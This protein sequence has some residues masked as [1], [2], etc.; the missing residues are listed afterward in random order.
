MTG[1]RVSVL[2][3]LLLALL[4][5][6]ALVLV[7][8]LAR[9]WLVFPLRGGTSGAPAQF[10]IADG[11]AVRIPTGEGAV[12]GAWFLPATGG[13]ATRT[14]VVVWF[15]G[16]GETVAA[17]APV[18]RE[19]RVPGV[20]LLAVD[21]R[22]YGAS[23]GRPTVAN[24]ERD[25]EAVWRWLAGRPDVDTT[26]VVVYGR[27]VGSG[28]AVALATTHPVAGLVLESAFTTLP[29]LARVHYPILPASLAGRG[30][31]NLTRI[32]RVRCPILF[33]HGDHD[34]TI[35]LWMGQA[36]ADRVRDRSEFWAIPGADHNDTYD[37]GGEEYVRR[38]Q[39][40]VRRAVSAPGE[41]AGEVVRK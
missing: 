31:D 37:V 27:S 29:A 15:H 39:A 26:R 18:L 24:T 16:N 9:H 6:P 21:F 40:F 8:F 10:R 19:F 41:K 20:A 2:R 13:E 4:A 7:A 5:Y 36:L 17:L 3:L 23:T 25:M 11:E 35:P 14:G 34:T 1:R 33:V 32:E 12:L 30:F 38:F 28:P 22:G